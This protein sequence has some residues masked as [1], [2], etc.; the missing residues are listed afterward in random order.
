MFCTSWIFLPCLAF[1]FFKHCIKMLWISTSEFFGTPLSSAPTVS[2]SLSSPRFWPWWPLPG[3]GGQSEHNLERLWSESWLY[4]LAALWPQEPIFSL[5]IPISSPKKRVISPPT[6][7]EHFWQMRIMQLKHLIC[8]TRALNT[9]CVIKT[10][11]RQSS[12][13]VE[14]GQLG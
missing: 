6:T 8:E 11:K 4:H 13:A 9:R 12:Q 14:S 7:E 2:A 10:F 3:R 5:W 1:E